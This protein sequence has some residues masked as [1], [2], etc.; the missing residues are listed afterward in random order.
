MHDFQ[1]SLQNHSLC[2]HRLHHDLSFTHLWHDLHD[3]RFCKTD[4]LNDRWFDD[5]N[6]ILWIWLRV[7]G[8]CFACYKFTRHF[9]NDCHVTKYYHRLVQSE[10]SWWRRSCYNTYFNF[11]ELQSVRGCHCADYIKHIYANGS[12]SVPEYFDYRWARPDWKL[13]QLCRL[14]YSKSVKICL[15]WHDILY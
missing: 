10:L 13:C 11:E 5:P 1:H 6:S 8:R 3:C 12:Q 14:Q 9:S 7:R 15:Q 4:T 2:G